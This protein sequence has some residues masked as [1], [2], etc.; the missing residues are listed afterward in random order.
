M[1]TIKH[2]RTRPVASVTAALVALVA[3]AAALLLP[4]G[5]SAQTAVAPRNTSPPAITGTAQVDE[6]L[7]ASTGAWTGTQPISFT[8]QWLRCNTSGENCVTL[9]GFTDE[10]YTVR[11]G[12]VDRTL[13]VR[14]TARNNDGQASRLSASTA[15]VKAAAGPP[16]A[17]KLPSGETS[18]PVTSVPAT[19]RLVVD[20]V[21]FSPNPVRSRETPITVRIKV[22]DTRG[23]VVRDALVFLR[24]TP[25]VT[26][27]P[28]ERRTEQDGTVAY[29]VQPEADFIVRNGYS[30]QFYMKAFRQGDPVLAGVAGSRLVQV[31]TVR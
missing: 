3:L 31:A 11:E 20:R 6:T 22:K 29:T 10:T 15:A 7:R 17:I 16:G 14:V 28:E 9:T 13:R 4:T 2:A 23:F 24:S 26:T 25:V 27:T 30:T 5:G 8:F 18:I 19:Q 1:T 21:D 12:D